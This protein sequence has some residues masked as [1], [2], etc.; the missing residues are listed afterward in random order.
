[1]QDK[2]TSVV[3]TQRLAVCGSKVGARA[4]KGTEVTITDAG[5]PVQGP[6][7]TIYPTCARPHQKLHQRSIVNR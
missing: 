2:K 5:S 3:A 1:M 7:P 4:L 6:N